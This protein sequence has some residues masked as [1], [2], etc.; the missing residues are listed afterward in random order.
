[1]LKSLL[2]TCFAFTAA[3][4]FAQAPPNDNCADAIAVTAGVTYDF[5]TTDATTDGPFHGDSPCPSA[6]N[7][8]LWKDVWYVFTPD[9]SGLADWTLCGSV[10]Y[11]SK[12]AVY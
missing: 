2:L 6:T 8:T 12:I 1:M 3:L 10:F 7:D 5:N 11:D 4:S 9:F